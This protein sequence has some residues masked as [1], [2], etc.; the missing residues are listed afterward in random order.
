MLQLG[1]QEECLEGVVVVVAW[2]LSVAW[3]IRKGQKGMGLPD[4]FARIVTLFL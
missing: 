1:E 2:E 4:F 3:N